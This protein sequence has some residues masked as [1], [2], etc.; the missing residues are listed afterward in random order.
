MANSLFRTRKVGSPQAST[1]CA[2]GRAR[3]SFLRRVSGRTPAAGDFSELLRARDLVGIRTHQI[4]QGDNS[5]ARSPGGLRDHS[6]GTQRSTYWPVMFVTFRLLSSRTMPIRFPR[7]LL[8]FVLFPWNV[9]A[10]TVSPPQQRQLVHEIFQQ[11]IAINTVG[12]SGTTRA[13]RALAERLRAAGFP[14]KDVVL[15]GDNRNKQSL[16]VRLRGTGRKEPILFMAHL[17]VVEARREDWSFEPFRLTERD[18]YFYGRGTADIKSEV[19]D[20]V[21]NLLRLKSEG[22]VPKRD[23]IL[24]LTA[25]EEGGNDNGVEWLVQHRPDLIRAAYA[26]NTDAGGAQIEDGRRLR[27]P[28]QT[29]E[30]VYATFMFEVTNPGGH[31]S[32]PT[33]DNAIYTLAKALE[34]LS[35]YQFPVRL[36]ETTRTFFARLGEQHGGQLG[37]DLRAVSDKADTAA[38]GRLSL[39][40]MY[41]S[42]MRT[43]CVATMLNAGHAENALP[44][45]ARATIQCRLL[46]GDTPAQAR[47]TLIRVLGDSQ[48]HVRVLGTPEESPASPLSPEVMSAVERVTKQMWP[49]VIVLPVMDPW[50][51]DSR[52]LRVAGTP[53][54]GISGI[55]Y[56]ID[57]VRSHGKDERILVQSFYEGVEFMYHLMKELS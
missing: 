24:A 11:L 13:A 56:D 8:A 53:V 20:L 1:S 22:Y 26:I 28:V 6:F 33:R 43:T 37:S 44:Q 30:K 48:V 35:G 52:I 31:S 5:Y 47:D 9:S 46:P 29:S 49:G 57:D 25:D 45:R 40:P 51:S 16:V 32:L 36:T 10:Q 27:N 15:A 17:D 39:I 3:Q 23:I 19:A 21:A 7:Q 4:C 12:D 2:S 42:S 54:Y 14:A 50:S 38:I 34:R 41:N 55:F 18:G